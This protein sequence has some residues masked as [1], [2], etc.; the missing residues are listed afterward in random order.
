M[1]TKEKEELFKLEVEN[2]SLLEGREIKGGGEG[3]GKS[4]TNPGCEDSGDDCTNRGCK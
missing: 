1:D 3:S 2:L 4:C